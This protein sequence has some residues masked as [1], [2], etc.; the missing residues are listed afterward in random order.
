MCVVISPLFEGD[1]VT[2]NLVLAQPV[3]NRTLMIPTFAVF[4]CN[5]YVRKSLADVMCKGGKNSDQYPAALVEV[6][7]LGRRR[8]VKNFVLSG[9]GSEV[10]CFQR[11]GK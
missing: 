4:G 7:I 11:V 6:L 1:V 8:T 3:Q 2:G 5:F 10:S 9:V